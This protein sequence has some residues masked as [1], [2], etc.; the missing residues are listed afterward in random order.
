MSYKLIFFCL[1]CN[2]SGPFAQSQDTTKFKSANFDSI[3]SNYATKGFS[4]SILLALN[5]KTIINK[6]I[7]KTCSGSDKTIDPDNSVFEIG[8]TSKQFTTTA[9]LLLEEK[10][11]LSITDNLEKY[12]RD[13]PTDKKRSRSPN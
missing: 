7:G 11:K 8:S 5:G 1:L 10:G 2:L 12:F 6:G 9:I 13:I 3:I 4:G